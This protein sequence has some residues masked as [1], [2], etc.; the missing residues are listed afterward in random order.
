MKVFHLKTDSGDPDAL[1]DLE[2]QIMANEQI[3]QPETTEHTEKEESKEKAKDAVKSPV[4]DLDEPSAT[5][6]LQNNRSI[7]AIN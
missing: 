1:A 2:Q 3:M 6:G 4:M 7:Y 5:S